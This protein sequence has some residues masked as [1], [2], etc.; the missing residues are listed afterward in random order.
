MGLFG[1]GVASVVAAVHLL[2]GYTVLGVLVSRK[3][4]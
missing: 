2:V 3:D 1:E 4:G